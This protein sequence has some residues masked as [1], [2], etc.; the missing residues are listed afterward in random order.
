M[1]CPKCRTEFVDDVATCPDCN[2]DLVPDQPKVQRIGEQGCNALSGPVERLPLDMESDV[3]LIQ[4]LLTAHGFEIQVNP[5]FGEVPDEILVRKDDLPR[6]KKF[7]E[8]YQ[9]ENRWGDEPSGIN[10]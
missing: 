2:L 1:F 6:I 3:A 10:W 5:G 8:E 4:S 9:S 7:L